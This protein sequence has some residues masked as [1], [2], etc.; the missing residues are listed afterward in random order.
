MTAAHQAHVRILGPLQVED[1]RGPVAL[2]GHKPRTLLAAL[3]VAGG[4][5]VPADRLL[6]ELWGDTPPPGAATAL[7]AYVSRLRGALGPVA[8]LHHRL[9][10]Y[11]LDLGATE[12][13]A[14]VFEQL[15]GSARSAA[16]AGDHE[17]ALTDADAALALWR[18]DVLAEFA[19]A[20]FAAV[21]TAR[22]TE[23]RTGA[24]EV[25]AEALL[26]LGRAAEAL[27]EL[28][29]VVRRHPSR[30]RP[31]VARMRAL[32]ATGR[33]ADALAAYHELRTRLAD[34]LGVEPAAPARSLY[35]RIL[36][37]DPALATRRRAGNLPRQASSFVGRSRE[38]DRVAAALRAGPLVTLTGVGG[39]GK[40]RLAV[41]V[42]GRVRDGF[43]DGVWLCELAALPDGSP[44]GHAVAAALGIQQRPGRSIEQTVIEY[45]RPRG[46]A[47]PGGQLRARARP[48]RR[49]GRRRPGA[50]PGR[51]RAGDQ[52]GG[53][54]RRG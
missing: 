21:P 45:L 42:A 40:S 18:G 44:V 5:V 54:G 25:R 53:A 12:L 51:R 13:D 24:E 11:C 28:D 23:L 3:V 27:P 39:A 35:R 17:Q 29:A 52:P 31:A 47:A 50:V 32:Y 43:P 33:Q 1:G 16:G 22:W 20:E 26:E 48:R 37:H 19:E 6:A 41:E 9:P 14:A 34:D 49:A 46:P 2:G 38:V 15:V 10:G 7:R 8:T 4:E 36:V 30:E